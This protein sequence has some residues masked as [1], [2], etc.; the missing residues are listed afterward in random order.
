MTHLTR[1]PDCPRL[2]NPKTNPWKLAGSIFVLA[3]AYLVLFTPPVRAQGTY[4]EL[5]SFGVVPG[6]T[7]EGPLVEASD[8]V[9]Y[10]TTDSGGANGLGTVCSVKSDG[11]GYTVLYSFAGGADGATPAA[12][13]MLG[14]DGMLYGT[15]SAGGAANA[16]TIFKIGRDGS[17]YAVLESFS[18]TNGDGVSPRAPVIQGNDGR[19]Y[20]TTSAGGTGNLGTVFRLSTSGTGYSILRNFT[21]TNGDGAC[22]N[23]ALLQGSNSV[24]YGTTTFGGASLAG[25]VFRMNPDGSGY[26][27]IHSF[28]GSEGENPFA[29]LAQGTNGLLYGT[30]YFGGVN[31]AHAP[32]GTLFELNPDGSGFSVLMNFDGFADGGNPQGPLCPAG[33][34]SFFVTLV[35]G[36]GGGRGAILNVDEFGDYTVAYN[37]GDS[38]GDGASP[39]SGIV[40]GLDGLLYGT[41]TTDGQ[42]GNGTL[43]SLNPDGTGYANLYPFAGGESDPTGPYGTLVQ[44][45]DNALYGIAGGGISNAG[46]VFRLDLDG[47]GARILHNFTGAVGDGS[48]PGGNLVEGSDGT[49]YGITSA[50][51]GVFGAGTV[52]KLGPDGSGY[53]ALTNFTGTNGDGWDP[54]TGLALGNDGALYGATSG[55]GSSNQFY[56]EGTLFKINATGGGYRVLHTFAPA[57]PVTFT[58]PDGTFPNAGL[59]CASDGV[60]YGTAYG[61]GSNNMGTVFRMNRDSSGFQVLHHFAGGVNDGSRSYGGLR[62]GADG[63]LYGTTYSEGF[64]GYGTVYKLGKDGSGYAV[65]G[66]FTQAGNVGSYPLGGATPY[67]T[68]VYGT[69]IDGGDQSSSLYGYGTLF[70]VATNTIDGIPQTAYAF[71]GAPGDGYGPSGGLTLSRNG[72]F[73]GTAGGGSETNGIV[74]LFAPPP[75]NDSFSNRTI[76]SGA[77]L[78]ADGNNYSAGTETNEPDPGAGITPHSGTVWW[79]WTAPTNGPVSILSDGSSFNPLIDVYAG[80]TLTG[81]TCIASNLFTVLD[82]ETNDPADAGLSNRVSFTATAGTA[83]QIQVCG[84]GS[85]G[86][87]HLEVGPVALQVL[88]V[89]QTNNADGTIS[90]GASVG[91]GNSGFAVPGPLRVRVVAQPGFSRRSGLPAELPL[92]A[93]LTLGTYPLAMTGTVVPGATANVSLSGTCPA[94]IVLDPNAAGF[95]WGVFAL[96]E[97]EVGTNWYPLDKDVLFLDNPVWPVIGGFLGTGGGVIRINPSESISA[98]N[99]GYVQWQ[100]GP[101]AAVR[102]G[103]AWR[104]QGDAVYSNGSNYIRAVISTNSVVVEFKPIPGWNLPSGQSVTIMPDAISNYLA[105]YTVTN[106]VL[107]A[108]PGLGLALSGTTGTVYRIESRTSLATG[109]WSPVITNTITTSGFNAV[110]PPPAAGQPA[111]FY[112]AVWL[113]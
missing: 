56:G 59:L 70:Q 66:N 72:V 42:Y 111:T 49:L 69:T 58:N 8:G 2:V 13:L 36:G 33:D 76:L 20:G 21:G 110:L 78:A 79:S 40:V 86:L 63:L 15:T 74:F 102:A 67:G 14:S 43:F 61:G 35:I 5:K 1:P 11:T 62:E 99:P 77:A 71:E 75:A 73:Y 22:P 37:F 9:F 103:A 104:L 82:D 100:L 28:D 44:G 53:L 85:S 30:T 55:G 95:G 47:T 88:D 50:S 45:I 46:T 94:A 38:L 64:A 57:D 65:I 39:R 6:V 24:L 23:A 26:T 107:R 106:P 29:P 60:L 54:T 113:P 32:Q 7:V 12:G 48:S 101:P 25:T 89:T 96:L 112:R 68:N 80:N 52:F 105:F 27:N 98:A 10:A 41:T 84:I 93:D 18:G 19:L 16:G 87:I 17:G 109:S 90:F 81:L 3:I 83:Y 108:E 91:V 31:P 4:R 92:P 97:E 34:G 51:G